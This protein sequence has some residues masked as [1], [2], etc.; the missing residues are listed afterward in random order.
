MPAPRSSSWSRVGVTGR[1]GARP[2]RRRR[3]GLSSTP[4]PRGTSMYATHVQWPAPPCW[5]RVFGLEP[6]RLPRQ[7]QHG[8]PAHV[9]Q[10]RVCLA[11]AP[12]PGTKGATKQHSAMLA[13]IPNTFVA[14]IQGRHSAEMSDLLVCES[15]V[16]RRAK[17]PNQQGECRASELS[18][19]KGQKRDPGGAAF[20][21]Q[22]SRKY[23]KTNEEGV[24]RRARPA[25]AEQNAFLGHHGTRSPPGND[26]MC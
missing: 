23:A 2:P 24:W 3:A 26:V 15:V 9:D 7:L 20:L 16:L 8:T 11:E 13:G 12:V 25:S 4:V 6:N 21:V 19:P 14:L 10:V 1:S 5:R 22:L 17:S 18:K